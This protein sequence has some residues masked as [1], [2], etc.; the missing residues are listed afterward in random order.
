MKKELDLWVYDTF[1]K[2]PDSE[3]HS[4]C[5]YK[6]KQGDMLKAKL[7]IELPEKKIEITESQFDET[8]KE[9]LEDS[10]FS[11]VKDLPPLDSVKK[12][13]GFIDE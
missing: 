12:K 2:Y 13:L 5:A 6:N 1:L 7:I 8:L 3:L 9:F 4:I 11:Y 10:W